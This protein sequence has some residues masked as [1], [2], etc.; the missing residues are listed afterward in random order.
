MSALNS[1]GEWPILKSSSNY[2]LLTYNWK[3]S[4][5]KIYGFLGLSL[6]FLISVQPNA[7]DTLVDRIYIRMHSIH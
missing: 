5:E 6:H 7:N 3:D 1:V 2:Y 4:Q